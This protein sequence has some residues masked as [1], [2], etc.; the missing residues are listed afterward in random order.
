MLYLKDIEKMND[1][2]LTRT[3]IG[4]PSLFD[5][6]ILSEVE[7]YDYFD[8]RLLSVWD[9]DDGL[10]YLSDCNRYAKLSSLKKALCVAINVNSLTKIITLDDLIYDYKLWEDELPEKGK[11]IQVI[12]TDG[13]YHDYLFRCNCQNLNC[14]E[15]RHK[16][17]GAMIISP[18]KWRYTGREYSKEECKPVQLN[19]WDL[20]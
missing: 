1:N 6:S 10:V 15:I 17:G 2:R 14:Q 5:V 9:C 7:H 13:K 8:G 11:E 12:D 4:K 16:M 19:I 20:V 18:D 3:V